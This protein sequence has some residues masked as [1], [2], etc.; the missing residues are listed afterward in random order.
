MANINRVLIQYPPHQLLTH[1]RFQKTLID[2]FLKATD[3]S[4]TAR[5]MIGPKSCVPS[6]LTDNRRVA[7]LLDVDDHDRY[8]SRNC[9]SLDSKTRELRDCAIMLVGIIEFKGVAACLVSSTTQQ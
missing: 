3:P 7:D 9:R 8:C 5:Y 6:C 1:W 2:N 4:L